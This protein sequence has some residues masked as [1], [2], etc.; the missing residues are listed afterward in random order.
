MSEANA[1]SGSPVFVIG[2]LRS[3]ASLVA[4]TLD[5][6]P[7]FAQIDQ[8]LWFEPLIVG[9]YS[10]YAHGIKNRS[11]S[12]LDISGIELSDFL[13]HYGVATNELVM[14]GL[15]GGSY[16]PAY[17]ID[18]TPENTFTVPGLLRLFPNAKFIHVVRDVEEVVA[19]LTSVL[20]RQFY[21]SRYIRTKESVA[22]DHWM[23]AVGA[24]VRAEAAYGSGTVLRVRRADLIRDPETEITRIC[25]FLGE[26]FDPACL[27]PFHSV[28]PVRTPAPELE[29]PVTGPCPEEI[30]QAAAFLNDAVVRTAPP[31]QELNQL[32]VDQEEL[33]AGRA[34]AEGRSMIPEIPGRLRDMD[35]VAAKKRAARPAPAK[36]VSNRPQEADHSGSLLG[37][38][39]SLRPSK[40]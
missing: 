5:Q 17:W 10:A 14:R 15:R 12:H 20:N 7:R 30:K 25:E 28:D 27:R 26:S 36:P 40:R 1:V 32:L 22:Y 24:G 33:A 11:I 31:V 39:R 29:L 6:H 23:K 18:A 16:Q 37:R 34:W 2:S 8:T 35:K 3:G 4:L 9:L 19:S 21:K 13:R 38:I